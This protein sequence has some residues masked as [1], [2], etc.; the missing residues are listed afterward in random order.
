M[1]IPLINQ[2]VLSLQELNGAFNDSVKSFN[3]HKW[4]HLRNDL[5]DQYVEAGSIFHFPTQFHSGIDDV[6]AY[7][8]ASGGQ[9]HPA[10]PPLT[11]PFGK[12]ASLSGI[13]SW[14]DPQDAK[15]TSIV[16][17]FVFVNRGTANKADWRALKLFATSSAP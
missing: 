9:F 16:Y 7:L 17:S 11:L 5:L 15:E 3:N 2:I 1:A 12:T 13:A 4:A 10:G 14:Q 8:Q 6:I